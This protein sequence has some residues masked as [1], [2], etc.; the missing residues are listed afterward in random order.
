MIRHR[1]LLV[2]FAAV[3]AVGVSA[4]APIPETDI[5]V[6]PMDTTALNEY[7]GLEAY[8]YGEIEGESAWQIIK[9]R[10]LGR[11]QQWLDRKDASFD[12]AVVL[13]VVAILI[14]ALVLL[15]NVRQGV[16]SGGNEARNGRIGLFDQEVY[17]ATLP[18]RIAQC[19]S[20][21]DM[22]SAFRYRFLL[23][24][25]DLDGSK[26][27]SARKY[28]TN[29]DYRREFAAAQPHR[30]NEF[31]ALADIFDQVFYGDKNLDAGVYN[32]TLASFER[33]SQNPGA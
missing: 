25:T 8:Q 16:I 28:K 23:L 24:L 9:R 20:R 22:A 19:E 2:F 27:I 29:G 5:V 12:V 26:V 21:D 6:R 17:V 4:Q 33:V 18:E 7:R 31:E 30:S 3:L 1:L 10:V 13:G 32:A 14:I 11:I 15:L